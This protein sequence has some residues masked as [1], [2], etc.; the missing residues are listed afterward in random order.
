MSVATGIDSIAFIGTGNMGSPMTRCLLE[1]GFSVRAYDRD[2]AKTAALAVDGAAA[3]GSVADA[4]VPGGVVISM[5]TDD[6]ALRQ[7]SLDPG[8]VLDTLS[9]G[10]VHVSMSTVSPELSEDLADRY[11][12]RGSAYLAA[13][14]LG[15]PD[16]AAAGRLSI[17]LAGEE[18]AKRRVR[19]ALDAIGAR[20]HDFGEHAS[21]ANAAKVAIN[22]LIVAA[23]EGLAEAG[24]LAD[25]AGVDRAQL[26]RAAVESGLFGGAV[27][28]GYGSMI[29]EHRY[30]PALFRVALGLKDTTLAERL[31]ARVGAELPIASLAREHLETAEA[32]G[33]GDEDWAVIGRVLAAEAGGR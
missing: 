17:L 3:A 10:G 1:A 2:A 29:A 11:R 30:T 19:P 20:V 32:A 23:I 18:A 7:I 27:Y 6:A 8:G 28:T 14:V 15:R 21:A 4:T 22:F 16:V 9:E 25:R 31:A 5:V 13:P 24:G 26:I 12:A 33:W